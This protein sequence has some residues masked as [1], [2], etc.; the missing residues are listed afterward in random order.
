ML[1]NNWN[2][3]SIHDIQYVG[4]STTIVDTTISYG[5]PGDYVN[6]NSNGKAYY[7]ISG[8]YDTVNYSLLSDTKM[9]FD[10]DT[11]TVNTLTTTDMVMTYYG[12]ETSPVNN[13]DNVIVLKR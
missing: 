8:S 6:F 12:R 4:A 13:W 10:G 1:Q 3:V 7:R 2:L 5:L 9:L 11:F